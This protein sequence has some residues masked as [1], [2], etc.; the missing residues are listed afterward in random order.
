ML[1]ALQSLMYIIIAAIYIITFIV[2]PFRI[3]SESME[4]TLLVGDFL[5]VTKQ[6]FPLSKIPCLFRRRQSSGAM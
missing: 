4:P 6:E 5:L 2:Q 1:N 3:P